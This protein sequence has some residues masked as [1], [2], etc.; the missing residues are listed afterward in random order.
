M[1][2]VHPKG[3]LSGGPAYVARGTPGTAPPR[4]LVS[5]SLSSLPSLVSPDS[6][7]MSSIMTQLPPGLLCILKN[8]RLPAGGRRAMLSITLAC[9]VSSTRRQQGRRPQGQGLGGVTA[10]EEGMSEPWE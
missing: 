1:A 9:K 7:Q 6:A 5:L 4:L 10:Q 3:W 8:H 2:V